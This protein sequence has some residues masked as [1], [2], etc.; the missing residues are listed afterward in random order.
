MSS[1]DTLNSHPVPPVPSSPEQQ[2]WAQRLADVSF[3]NALSITLIATRRNLAPLFLASLIIWLCLVLPVIGLPVLDFAALLAAQD[4]L[5]VIKATFSFR[6]LLIDLIV[7]MVVGSVAF[8]A[9]IVAVVRDLQGYRVGIRTAIREGLA[10]APSS[11]GAGLLVTAI[12]LSGLLLLVIPGVIGL[13]GLVVALPVCII[14]RPG[15]GRS[16]SRSWALTRGRRL[17]ILGL[18]VLLNVAG[19]VVD[20][21][22]G[23]LAA[24][25]PGLATAWTILYAVSLLAI[26]MPILAM[27]ASLYAMLAAAEARRDAGASAVIG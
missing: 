15:I 14:E 19:S 18:V 2:G 27:P 26:Q 21:I 3:G 10:A 11:A 25:A 20:Q 22:H 24:A 7:M 5:P 16:L 6:N 13:L 8:A 4:L 9:A 1:S 17:T 23:A 12:V